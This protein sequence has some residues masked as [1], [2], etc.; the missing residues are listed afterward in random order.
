M[1][2]PK[3]TR[4]CDEC[5]A[6]CQGWLTANI[7]GK[8]M[9]PGRPCHFASNNG[10]SIYKDRPENPCVTYKC[11]WLKDDGT[12]FPEWM[13]P[14]RS[15]VIITERDWENRLYWSVVECGKQIDS[16]ILNWIYLFAQ[17]ND[18]YL[19]IQVAGIRYYRGSPEFQHYVECGRK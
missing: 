16:K 13:K 10:C 14:D 12:I 1:I 7:Y 3:L 6:C 2:T 11:A 15:D 4:K 5:N 9:Y 18:I 17:A 8:E 19:E